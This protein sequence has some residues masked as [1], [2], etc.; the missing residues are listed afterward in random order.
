MK[1]YFIILIA[2]AAIVIGYF[3]GKSMKPKVAIVGGVK[4]V[5]KPSQGVTEIK[6]TT[7]PTGK[8]IITAVAGWDKSSDCECFS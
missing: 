3:I 8:K 7:D 5:V 6:T 4:P 1:W 2:V